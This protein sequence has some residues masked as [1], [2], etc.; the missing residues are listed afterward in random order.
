MPV[1]Q[2][3]SGVPW[4]MQDPLKSLERSSPGFSTIISK[5]TLCFAKIRIKAYYSKPITSIAQKS[6][7]V[8][9]IPTTAKSL[10]A[11]ALSITVNIHSH[12]P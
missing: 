11:F 3:Q 2:M 12:N 10:L 7:N 4:V 9:N 1:L 5:N 6:S 8:N